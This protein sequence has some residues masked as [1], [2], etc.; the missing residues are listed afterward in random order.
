MGKSLRVAYGEALAS[1]GE[2]N[3]KVV[4]LDADL[5]GATQTGIFK[6]KFPDR[7]F[8]VGIAEQNLV[9]IACGFAHEGLIPFVSTFAVF[10]TGR[11]FEIIRNSV[12]YCNLNVKFGFSHAG[13]SVGEDGGSHQAIEDISLMR[14]LPNMTV[15]A[16]CDEIQMQKAV[17][18]AAK[19]NGPVYI[20]TGRANV[21]VVTTDT[22]PFEV[23]KATILNE[24]N[25]A[26]IFTYGMMTKIAL[27]ASKALKDEG[28][29]VAVVDIHTIKPLDIET[30]INVHKKVKVSVTLEE[31]SIIGGLGSAVAEAIAGINGSKYFRVG[32]ED[33]FGHSGSPAELFKEYGLTAEHVI[34]IIKKNI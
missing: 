22:T 24:G 5:S 26:C 4:V 1:L 18:A 32:I 19:I 13:L 34:E 7:F 15:I 31:H 30:V 14:S 21:D 16:P 33:K 8:N 3:D 10:G 9:G 27:E 25:D 29:N 2:K 11:A 28:I 6:K 12:A 17:E 20:R 23:G